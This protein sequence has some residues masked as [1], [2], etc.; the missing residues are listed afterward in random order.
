MNN[1]KIRKYLRQVNATFFGLAIILL[2]FAAYSWQEFVF[3][4][5][6]YALIGGV[7]ALISGLALFRLPSSDGDIKNI[8]KVGIQHSWTIT[9]V[10]LAAAAIFPAP[11][12]DI[13]VPLMTYGAITIALVYMILGAF[14]LYKTR[15]ETGQFLSI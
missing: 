14:T 3:T 15:K 5:V 2:V 12:F 13:G 9:S 11:F 1:V 6:L 8:G 7:Q 4:G 10:G